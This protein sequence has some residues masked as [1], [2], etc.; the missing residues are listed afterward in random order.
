M[1]IIVIDQKTKIKSKTRRQTAFKKKKYEA[2]F[3][4]RSCD[5]CFNRNG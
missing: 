2:Q 3:T 4:D 5:A 1:E